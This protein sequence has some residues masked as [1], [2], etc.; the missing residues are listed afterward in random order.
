LLIVE[1][2][3]PSEEDNEDVGD[4]RQLSVLLVVG[5]VLFLVGIFGA[6]LA[7][8]FNTLFAQ[9]RPINFR[10]IDDHGKTVPRA[11]IT[12]I[13]SGSLP[14][15]TT[16][17]SYGR[18]TLSTLVMQGSTQVIV[19]ASDYALYREIVSLSGATDFTFQLT[20]REHNRHHLLVRVVDERRL[21]P[22]VGAEVFLM[23]DEEQY[24]TSTDQEGM[25]NFEFSS[26]HLAPHGRIVVEAADMLP[27]EIHV[28]GNAGRF[29]ELR[30][31][32]IE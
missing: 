32:M 20:H 18:A 4:M 7:H 21:A 30:L 15:R 5:V 25:A 19:D 9:E 27:G 22:V 11:Q 3:Q 24:E 23:F 6:Y 1:L 28:S 26:T 14:E 31:S 29:L 12:L 17:D 13:Q 8:S 10:I 2:D 16:S